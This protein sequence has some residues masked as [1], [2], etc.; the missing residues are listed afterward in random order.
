[1]YKYNGDFI[2]DYLFNMSSFWKLSHLIDYKKGN[3]LF[4]FIFKVIYYQ[5]LLVH[6]FI[7]CIDIIGQMRKLT[8][9]KKNVAILYIIY[10]I[11]FEW[12]FSDPMD[13]VVDWF[14]F[15]MTFLNKKDVCTYLVCFL[16]LYNL[17]F[18]LLN[19]NECFF[20]YLHE[21]LRVLRFNQFSH[22]VS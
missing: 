5:S 11:I 12:L 20:W 9:K 15:N 14:F 10:S 3:V 4:D 13:F 8:L 7:N 19:S 16:Y 22:T 2:L 18:C 17:L 21:R 6:Y 1:V